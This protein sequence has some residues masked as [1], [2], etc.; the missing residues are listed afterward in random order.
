MKNSSIQNLAVRCVIGQKFLHIP[1]NRFNQI[2]SSWDE[3]LDIVL[4]VRLTGH[5]HTLM[6]HILNETG[7]V[8]FDVDNVVITFTEMSLQYDCKATEKWKIFF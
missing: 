5:F 4:V 2:Q 3:R 1:Q 8:N 6:V 7:N